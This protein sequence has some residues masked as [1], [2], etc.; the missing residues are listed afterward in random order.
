MDYIATHELCSHL[1]H[2]PFASAGIHSCY[3]SVQ[4]THRFAVGEADNFRW[5]AVFVFDYPTGDYCVTRGSI[6]IGGIEY[7]VFERTGRY[8]LLSLRR[9]FTPTGSSP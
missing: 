8:A 4:E 9:R 2:P 3:L 6:K 7:G 1:G 5:A